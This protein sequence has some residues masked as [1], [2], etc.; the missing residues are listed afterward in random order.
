MPDPQTVETPAPLR[1]NRGGVVGQIIFCEGCCCGRVD[2][3][4][5]PFP[6]DLIKR[7][8]KKLKLNQTIQ[9]TIS[10]CLGPCDIPNV[11]CIIDRSSQMFWFGNLHLDVHY[12]QLIA[13]ARRCHEKNAFVEF[14]GNLRDL[15]FDRFELLDDSTD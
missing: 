11:V 7:E 13:W 15:A 6:K 14:P 2:R 12:Q 1:T 4:R 10:G 9:L 5:P 8:W 3:G